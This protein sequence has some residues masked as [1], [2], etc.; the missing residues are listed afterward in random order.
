MGST[1]KKVEDLVVDFKNVKEEKTLRSKIL[2]EIQ[3]LE[4]Q[5]EERM[6]NT[7]EEVKSNLKTILILKEMVVCID[8]MDM[9]ITVTN[10]K[11][12]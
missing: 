11:L 5:N 2:R 12:K 4:I 3:T 1:S 9:S 6:R 7:I 8:Y 10:L